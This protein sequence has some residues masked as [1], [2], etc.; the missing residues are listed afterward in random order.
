MAATQIGQT[1][2]GSPVRV[3]IGT[4]PGPV[5]AGSVHVAIAERGWVSA[6]RVSAGW[7]SAGWVSAALGVGGLG[8]GGLGVGGLGVG[9]LSCLVPRLGLWCL[10]RH[11]TSHARWSPTLRPV[12]NHQ[13][14]DVCAHDPH[15][16]VVRE[17]HQSGKPK[18]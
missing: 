7:V 5:A 17:L 15:Q 2:V 8:V 16:I 11:A 6:G 13:P 12:F 1:R 18:H 4:W 3:L 9:G 14:L 10:A